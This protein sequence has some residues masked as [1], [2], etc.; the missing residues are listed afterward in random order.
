MTGIMKAEYCFKIVGERRQECCRYG[1]DGDIV[2]DCRLEAI[3]G[4]A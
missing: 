1:G 3:N 2:D 4:L